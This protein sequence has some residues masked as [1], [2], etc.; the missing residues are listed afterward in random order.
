MGIAAVYMLEPPIRQD[1]QLL[2]EFAKK[3][4]RLTKKLGVLRDYVPG[5]G[6]RLNNQNKLPL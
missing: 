4:W 5:R 6:W 2:N 3:P 1:R